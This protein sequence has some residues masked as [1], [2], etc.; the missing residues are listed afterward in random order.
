MLRKIQRFI[1]LW[2]NLDAYEHHMAASLRAVN[3]ALEVSTRQA[4]VLQKAE[5]D[6]RESE[7]IWAREIATAQ[8]QEGEYARLMLAYRRWC[9]KQ[10]CV[11]TTRDLAEM[12]DDT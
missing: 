8:S 4:Q 12:V 10:G 5:R 6:L 3:A 11:P 2:R 9:E 1:A 7:E